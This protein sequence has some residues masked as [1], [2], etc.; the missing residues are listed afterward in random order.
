LPETQLKEQLLSHKIKPRQI[1][2]IIALKNKLPKSDPVKAAYVRKV[3]KD[4]ELPEREN[5]YFH[6]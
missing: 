1:D 6:E 2:Q 5:F 4:R 3:I